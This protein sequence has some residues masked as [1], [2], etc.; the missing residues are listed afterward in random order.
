MRTAG[1]GEGPSFLGDR[2]KAEQSSQVSEPVRA[3]TPTQV[4]QALATPS[5]GQGHL[6]AQMPGEALGPALSQSPAATTAFNL[7]R[8]NNS[9]LGLPW[10]PSPGQPSPSPTTCGLKQPSPKGAQPRTT[11]CCLPCAT[12]RLVSHPTRISRQAHLRWRWGP[13]KRLGQLRTDRGQP[14]PRNGLTWDALIKLPTWLWSQ[15]SPKAC[16]VKWS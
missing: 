1:R 2:V 3:R 12:A 5:W 13:R 7:G 16:G 6:Q 10:C 9:A 11:A 15:D 4:F 14:G 8:R